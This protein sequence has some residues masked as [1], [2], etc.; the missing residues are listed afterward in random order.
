MRPPFF[1]VARAIA[2]KGGLES[3]VSLFWP[4]RLDTPFFFN[5][6]VRESAILVKIWPKS[7]I[8]WSFLADLPTG[9]G[10]GKKFFR[11]I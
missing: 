7:A 2:T 10:G 1:C 9:P 4:D 5:K 8:F 11:K 6:R 3:I